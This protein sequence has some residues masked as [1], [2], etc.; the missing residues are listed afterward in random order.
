MAIPLDEFP[1]H[2]T[3]L[4]MQ[5]VSSSDRNFYD[6]CYL[7]AHDRTGNVF[8]VTGLGVYP[9]LG[10]IDA[11]AC[12][13]VGDTQ[14]AVHFSDALGDD[15]MSQQV[16][17]YRVEIVDP[18]NELRVVCDADDLGIGFDLRWTGAFPVVQEQP[19]LWRTGNKAILDATRFA[20][21]GNWAGE[22]RVAGNTYDVTPDIWCGTRD[23][24][25]GI[26]PVG[27][28]E[29]PGRAAAETA[30][31][32]GFWW[33]YLPLQFD[34]FAIVVIAQEDGQG[35]RTANDAVRV[36]PADSERARAG[37][38]VE[39]LG[40]PRFRYRYRPGTRDAVGVTIDCQASDGSPLVIEVE[41]KGYVVLASGCGYGSDPSWGHGQWKGRGWSQGIQV[42]MTAP[43]VVAMMPFGVIDHIGH[44]VLTD[45]DGTSREGWGLF[46]H[47]TMGAHVPSGFDD[48]GSVAG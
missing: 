8:L 45:V 7:N 33:S 19:H 31:D 40:W 22:L 47:A 41:S 20:Q 36:W 38:G 26:R 27:E 4:S 2:Q 34:D 6:R 14:H 16:G 10:V 35:N 1:I 39:L 48:F 28:P 11:Y 44:A 5:F 32:W 13:R 3:P 29:P 17:P 24:S 12:V 21:V 9:N 15:R 23:R 30:A 46:E 43:D 37:K 42:D 25:W 18:L